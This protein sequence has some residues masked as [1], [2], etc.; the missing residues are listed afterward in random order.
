M[1]DLIFNFRLLLA[2]TVYRKI[3]YRIF[4][5]D[6]KRRLITKFLFFAHFS[7]WFHHKIE[8]IEYWSRIKWN[9]RLSCDS[10]KWNWNENASINSEMILVSIIDSNAERFVTTQIHENLESFDVWLQNVQ[11]LEAHKNWSINVLMVIVWFK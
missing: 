6:E 10:I 9:E 11:I 1:S 3:T 2:V 4:F 8:M 7:F 5:T